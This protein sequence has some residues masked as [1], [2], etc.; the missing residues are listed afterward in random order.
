MTGRPPEFERSEA[1]AYGGASSQ[2]TSVRIDPD[3]RFTMTGTWC[4]SFGAHVSPQDYLAVMEKRGYKI[5]MK[6][7]THQDVERLAFAGPEGDVVLEKSDAITREL[8]EAFGVEPGEQWIGLVPPP[9]VTRAYTFPEPGTICYSYHL[10]VSG[11]R[12]PP[13][14]L[15]VVLTHADE[16]FRRHYLLDVRILA[17][18]PLKST[19]EAVF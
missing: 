14:A 6:L 12:Y 19:V 3:G 7:R 15:P 4:F 18:R 17:G 2:T 16:S 1:P 10:V 9:T 13:Q 5:G 11:V 8:D